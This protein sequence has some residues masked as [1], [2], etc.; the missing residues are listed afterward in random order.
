MHWPTFALATSLPARIVSLASLIALAL[1]ACGGKQLGGGGGSGGPGDAGGVFTEPDGAVCV[2]I[3]LSTYD[4]SCNQA[5]DCIS[6]TAGTICGGDCN[7]NR[8]RL[9]A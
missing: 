3:D 8:S 6:I 7:C 9:A 2:D 5:S 4:T 1:G